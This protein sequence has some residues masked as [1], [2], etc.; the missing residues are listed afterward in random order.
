M[1]ID[2]FWGKGKE[3]D[4]VVLCSLSGFRPVTQERDPPFAVP[5][6]PDVEMASTL[7]AWAACLYSFL[8]FTLTVPSLAGLLQLSHSKQLRCRNENSV[9]LEQ[10][11][12]QSPGLYRS[13]VTTRGQ[14]YIPVMPCCN[15][16]CEAVKF[17]LNWRLFRIKCCLSQSWLLAIL[18]LGALGLD[19][20]KRWFLSFVKSCILPIDAFLRFI[21]CL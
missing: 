21:L 20:F 1:N 19:F 17:T 2:E 12:C 18:K 11:Y 14:W 15:I 6:Q 7:H 10:C 13:D 16:P 4:T 8:P 3:D 9:Q 5:L